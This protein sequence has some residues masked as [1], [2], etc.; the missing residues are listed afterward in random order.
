[1]TA[2]RVPDAAIRSEV[3]DPGRSFIV[4]APAGSGKTELLVRRFLRLVATVDE[5]EEILAI[6]FTRKAAGEMRRR[7]LAL[8]HSAA[9]GSGPAGEAGSLAAA[10][11][12]RDTARGWQLL[13]H[14]ARLRISTID[15]LNAQLAAANPVTAGGNGLRRVTERAA[16][17]YAQAALEALQL[18]AGDDHL[19]QAA[20]TLLR[21]LDNRLPR[22]ATL[23]AAMLARRDQWLPLL[24][25]GP[26]AAGEGAL[27]AQ[28]EATLRRLVEQRLAALEA[29]LPDG[30]RAAFVA[31]SD[32]A[33]ANRG[34][35]LPAA[36]DDP[37]AYQRAW[38][39]AA[40]E[41]WTTDKGGWRQK[42]EVRG[43]FPPTDKVAKAQAKELLGCLADAGHFR[44]LLV[45]AGELPAP[46]YGEGQWR[47]LA[48][49]VSLL[50]AAAAALRLQFA[51]RGTTDFV[52]LASEALRA[53]AAEDEPGPAAERTDARLRHILI[54]EFQDTSRT[55][56]RLLDALTA[57]F[58]HGDG[59]TVFLVGDP[60]QSIYRFREAE[61]GLFMTLVAEAPGRLGLAPRTLAAN[62]R[63]GPA[64]V[65]WVNAVFAHLLPA[66]DDPAA[67]AVAFA[68]SEPVPTATPD[69]G[70]TLHSPADAATEADQVVALV[71]QSLAR[72]ATGSIGIL[73]RSRPQAALV[74]AA[75]AAA[76]IDASVVDLRRLGETTLA[77]DL[78]AL[79]RAL[80]HP[81]DRL[82][83]LAVLRAPWCGL[84]L[85]D[86]EALAGDEPD[87]V[88]PEL[89]A[90]GG[91]CRRLSADGQARVARLSDAVARVTARSGE[92][93]LRGRVEGLWHELG[94]PACAGA[95]L[96]IADDL[97]AYLEAADT[98]GDC[99]DPLALAKLLREQAVPGHGS[100]R[101]EVLT[102]HK[103][104]GLEFDTVIVPGLGQKVRRDDRPPL[105][106]R[107][108]PGDPGLLLAPLNAAGQGNDLLYELL[109][110]LAQRQ[111]R[112]EQDR[113]LYVACTRARRRLHLLGTPG[114]DGPA[115][116]S[117]LARLWP[118][119]PG[120]WPALATAG[121]PAAAMPPG[122]DWVQLPLR[123]L[124]ADWVRPLPPA[125]LAVPS[126]PPDLAPPPVEFAWASDLAR[127]TGI[128]VHRLLQL[129]A[130][131]GSEAWDTDRL[132]TLAPL[133]RRLLVA[134][135]VPPA[136]LPA[137]VNRVAAALGNT[138]AESRGRWL[139]SAAHSEARNEFAVT[140]WDGVQ[141]R[142]LVM[143]RTFL[144]SD[145]ERWI[146][147]Y[148][149]GSHEGGDL[150]G[151]LAAEAG[152]YAPQLAAYRAAWSA[153][154]AAR[155][156][157]AL[158]FPL[159]PRLHEVS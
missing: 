152:R 16:D 50:P 23:V 42:L 105:L 7:V 4:R 106:W 85:A 151:F 113:L 157:V 53:L 72:D 75:L 103:A 130:V 147:D 153:L 57:G 13:A 5:P 95:D 74:L 24:G 12:A 144:A 116:G 40:A 156:R 112:A 117:L 129:I 76:A 99:I 61:V 98:G 159:L 92:L 118:V 33:A 46:H 59:R 158:Y 137:A 146:I 90:S 27:R 143:D 55:Q 142:R 140:W 3:L 45:G 81:G 67:G 79:T 148:K 124:P 15:S 154:D 120:G 38:W 141:F 110:D 69:D 132:A 102:I 84:T 62:F 20:A 8:L 35:T 17:L 39:A 31:L 60:M 77:H 78:L 48:A 30:L 128:V 36:G 64:V 104:K 121:D 149:T 54:D 97:F 93:D 127:R 21:H 145:G 10:A 11:L 134:T 87:A 111:S 108:L 14:P 9:A 29:A 49:L 150:D 34:A 65:S 126:P 114:D 26:S 6:T 25:A 44:E 66:A 131:E 155:I 51:A 115:Q 71:R 119:V 86:L 43:G 2:G 100:S 82:A 32:S 52:E 133:A 56:H 89:L 122:P 22:A 47:A 68:P 107:E 1:M 136:D 125:A 58:V 19:A 96:A 41:T 73:V 94:G 28:L 91:R 138:L 135:G 83:W 88:I 123:R 109:W 18:V 101:V 139:L 37:L 70:V 80:V 63:S